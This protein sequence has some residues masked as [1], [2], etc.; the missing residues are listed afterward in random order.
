MR[1][2]LV[3][4]FRHARLDLELRTVPLSAEMTR[5]ASGED[6]TN[7]IVQIDISRE[8]T[9]KRGERFRVYPGAA[10]NRLEVLGVDRQLAQLVLVVAERER[11]FLVR[12]GPHAPL[13]TDAVVVKRDKKSVWVEQLTSDRERRFLCGMDEQHLFIALLPEP[14]ASVREAHRALR[15]V[16]LDAAEQGAPRPTIRQGEWFFVA[17]AA[18]VEREISTLARKTLHAVRGRGIAEAAG[19]VR[20]GRPHVAEEIL[21]VEGIPDRYGDRSKRV[22]ARGA[23]RHPDHRTVELPTWRL[24]L[25]NREALEQPVAGVG[26]ID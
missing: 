13:P 23:I 7:D 9:R 6:R 15:P 18:E 16:E 26:W 25:P 14:V 2:A 12:F 3:S 24:V 19:I 10:D 8:W 22:Y 4:A 20:L 21:V 1:D 17:L 5:T 11:K